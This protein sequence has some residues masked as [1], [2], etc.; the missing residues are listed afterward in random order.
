MLDA[1]KEL[2]IVA[3]SKEKE[4][5]NVDGNIAETLL[6][7]N[8]LTDEEVLRLVA[9]A[10]SRKRYHIPFFNTDYGIQMRL[11]LHALFWPWRSVFR[12]LVK[13]RFSANYV[14]LS[15]IR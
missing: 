10:R 14:E 2:L 7:D 4:D 11:E 15:I 3:D 8:V 1:S 5:R 13:Q 12:G 6:H 9:A